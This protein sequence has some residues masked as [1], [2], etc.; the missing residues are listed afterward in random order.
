LGRMGR[1]GRIRFPADFADVN[2]FYYFYRMKEK[3]SRDL[4]GYVV[5]AVIVVAIIGIV[6][7]C[8]GGRDRSK[9]TGT[10]GTSKENGMTVSK[11]K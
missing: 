10:F 7:L 1:M 3:Y 8:G 9:T 11:I 2:R 4:M 5:I 6:E